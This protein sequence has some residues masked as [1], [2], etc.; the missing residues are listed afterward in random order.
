[1]RDRVGQV[2]TERQRAEAA[3]VR[4]RERELVAGHGQYRFTAY[5]TVT[6]TSRVELE[7]ACG[8]VEQAAHACLLEIR[9]LYGEQDQAFAFTLPLCR[10]L[11]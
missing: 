11:R 10:G 7:E 5:L 2:T 6:G 4:R 1:M 8:Q 3:D 9:R